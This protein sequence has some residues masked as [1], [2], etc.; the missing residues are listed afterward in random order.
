MAAYVE[1]KHVVIGYIKTAAGE[2]A[3]HWHPGDCSMPMAG[4]HPGWL[5]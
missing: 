4:R 3:R 1:S 2:V 5:L